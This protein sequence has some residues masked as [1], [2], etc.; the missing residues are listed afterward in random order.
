MSKFKSKFKSDSPYVFIIY[1]HLHPLKFL[2]N[3]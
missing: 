2:D 3:G 1:V